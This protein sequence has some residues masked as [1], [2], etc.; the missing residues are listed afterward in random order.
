MKPKVLRATRRALQYGNPWLTVGQTNA[1]SGV[2]TNREEVLEAL[3][4]L[5]SQG[6]VV[7]KT[8]GDEVCFAL[9]ASV[10]KPKDTNTPSIA[11]LALQRLEAAPGSLYVADIANAQG[12]AD[13]SVRQALAKLNDRGYVSLELERGKRYGQQW[14]I[15]PEGRRYLAKKVPGQQPEEVTA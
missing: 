7:E 3:M 12:L 14:S 8:F 1:Y 5:V 4:L 9:A 6:A 11:V 15:T 13:A 10:S 2:V